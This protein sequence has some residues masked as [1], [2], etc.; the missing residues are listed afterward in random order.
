MTSNT[1]LNVYHGGILRLDNG[2]YER[3][4]EMTRNI[5]WAVVG[6]SIFFSAFAWI[7]LR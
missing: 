2:G 4:S 6:A 5:L 1:T 7:A 3:V